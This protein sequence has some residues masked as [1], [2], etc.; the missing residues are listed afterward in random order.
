MEL[1]KIDISSI[2]KYVKHGITRLQPS[3]DKGNITDFN[4]G[5]LV[6]FKYIEGLILKEESAK[7]QK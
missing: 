4:L 2:K 1:E 5:K 6:V 7:I 3:E